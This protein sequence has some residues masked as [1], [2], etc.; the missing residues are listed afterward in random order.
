[1]NLLLKNLSFIFYHK[2]IVTIK[3]PFIITVFL[4][5][6]PKVQINISSVIHNI[7]LWF[8]SSL[9]TPFSISAGQTNIKMPLS[10]SYTN[11]TLIVL[12]PMYV[13]NRR[14]FQHFVRS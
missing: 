10:T 13:N 6:F 3:I 12:V 2:N 5:V 1:M 11:L 9:G 7:V 14:T 8:G 4:N